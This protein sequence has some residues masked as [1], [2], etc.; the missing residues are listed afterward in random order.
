[1][2]VQDAVAAANRLAN[3]LRSGTVTDDDLH[4]IQKRR[5]LPVRFTQ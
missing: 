2:A 3:P 5:T 4:A 1:M